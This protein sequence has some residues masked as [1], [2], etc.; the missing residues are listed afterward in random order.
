M[1]F[2]PV[3]ES[4]TPQAADLKRHCRVDPTDLSIRV[5]SHNLGVTQMIGWAI[6]A[7]RT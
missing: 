7:Q 5:I 2:L 1:N 4:V 3:S 6:L